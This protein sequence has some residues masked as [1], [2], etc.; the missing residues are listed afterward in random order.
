M[1]ILITNFVG[2]LLFVLLCIT[3][4]TVMFIALS[5]IWLMTTYQFL[6]KPVIA[7][8]I[9]IVSITLCYEIVNSYN[10]SVQDAIKQNIKTIKP[11]EQKITDKQ[12]TPQ[13]QQKIDQQIKDAQ[14][15][16]TLMHTVNIRG[17]T[18]Y[19]G[20]QNPV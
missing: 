14:K 5:V 10:K 18:R 16:Q 11:P 13:E 20:K 12:L 9:L 1:S 6:K 7:M 8:L 17:K 15:I 2:L 19:S 4:T 3:A